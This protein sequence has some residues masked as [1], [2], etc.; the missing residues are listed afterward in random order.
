MKIAIA[1]F[2]VEGRSNYEYFSREYPGAE[3]VIVD[4]NEQLDNLPTDALSR[5]GSGVLEE[6]D[7]FDIVVRTAGL[8]PHK[9]RTRGK[10][11]SAT[12]EF[13]A[14]CPAKIIGVTGTKGKGT[15]C[16]LIVSMLES[17]GK[18]V[19]LVG[20]IGTPA[21]DILP[22]I[23]PSDVVVYELSSF[24]LWDLERSPQV[25]V[26]LMIEPDHQDV[27]SS[28]EEYV[29]AKANITIHQSENDLVVYH[30]QNEFSRQIAEQSNGK[31]QRFAVQDDGGAYV[32]LNNFCVQGHAICSVDT[33]QL[34]GDHNQDNACAAITVVR[35]IAPD[36]TNKQ[37]SAGLQSFTG[38]PHRL[39]FVREV[40]GVRYFDDSISTTP[41]SA[42]A[43]M[44]SFVEQ[45]VIILGGSDKGAEYRSV[46]EKCK[47][48]NSSVIAI[49]QTGEKIASL[50]NELGVICRR[51]DTGTM[52]DFV[53]GAQ[54]MSVIGGVVL[55]SPASASFGMFKNYADRG[56]QFIEAVRR[57]S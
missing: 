1:G 51:Y 42:I 52:Q 29:A 49:G 46:V 22:D 41:G 56:D 47:L 30:P 2:G 43:A 36:V 11:W 26:V 34:V 13:F 12:N 44:D 3:V 20:N 15:T 14:K 7:D 28:F 33:L 27:H 38:L 57:L 35:A 8:S 16:S 53:L 21:L 17:A 19:H 45:K 5:Q 9:V 32:D 24:Q 23:Q 10:V 48:T 55:L 25:A 54:E 4:E 50:C 37:I 39:K 31:R 18:K 40:A 6:L